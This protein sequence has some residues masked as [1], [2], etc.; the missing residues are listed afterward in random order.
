MTWW[1]IAIIVLI[2]AGII[3][4]T[5][6]SPLKKKTRQEYL[7]ELSRFLEGQLSPL[8]EGTN[9]Y[10]IAFKFEGRDFV[11]E[12]LEQEGFQEKVH[13]AFLKTQTKSSLTMDF[14]EEVRMTIKSRVV[15]AS[16]ISDKPI[17]KLNVP[18]SLKKFKI[19]ANH[20]EKANALFDDPKALRIF[21][22][23][24][25]TGLRGEA[26][27]T[28]RLQTGLIILEFTSNMDMRPNLFELLH[29]PAK[30]EQ[31]LRNLISLAKI[32]EE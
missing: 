25:N 8:E 21:T 20:I 13:K 12:D 3:F 14:T 30:I 32:L 10:Q 11:Y 6:S 9:N 24:A 28:L 4:L 19:F 15:Q 27:M 26:V 31:D 2:V 16:E 22:Y 29:S 7:E 5:G 1:I 18:K 17:E 23:Y